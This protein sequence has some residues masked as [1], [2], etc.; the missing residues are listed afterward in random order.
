MAQKVHNTTENK[1][2]KILKMPENFN[3]SCSRGF[4]LEILRSSMK[5]F[6]VYININHHFLAQRTH[7]V[8]LQMQ[9]V[10]MS[11]HI[12]LS[13]KHFVANITGKLTSLPFM[14]FGNV[15]S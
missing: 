15:N 3:L 6:H 10:L 8:I 2:L 14:D 13:G 9:R 12:P 1:R 5:S 11:L 4:L 7:R